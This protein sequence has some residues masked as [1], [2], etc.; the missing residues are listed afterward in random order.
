MEIRPRTGLFYRGSRHVIPQKAV[1]NI[2]EI[3]ALELK[4]HMALAVSR[5]SM[6]VSK[7]GS[8]RQRSGLF[9]KPTRTPS[10]GAAL[11]GGFHQSDDLTGHLVNG[12]LR[13][14]GE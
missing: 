4:R 14:G 1:G 2:V 8:E 13:C 6:F 7:T 11:P 3:G 12:G 10:C 9:Q 5:L